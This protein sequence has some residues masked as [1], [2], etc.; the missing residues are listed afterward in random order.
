MHPFDERYKKIKESL[1]RIIEDS[2]VEADIA[3]PAIFVHAL[4]LAKMRE[5]KNA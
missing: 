1:D 2:N 5:K 4:T 3:V